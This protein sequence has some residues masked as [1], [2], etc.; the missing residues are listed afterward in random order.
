MRVCKHVRGNNVCMRWCTLQ[1][2]DRTAAAAAG[3]LPP[4]AA[5]Q[6]ENSY[7]TCVR[8]GNVPINPYS[9]HNCIMWTLRETC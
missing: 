5:C 6:R 3:P 9:F 2:L 1:A 4:S 7:Q 8:V